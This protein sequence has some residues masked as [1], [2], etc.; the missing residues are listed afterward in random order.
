M[1][2]GSGAGLKFGFLF[3]CTAGGDCGAGFSTREKVPFCVRLWVAAFRAANCAS[4]ASLA[5]LED[6]DLHYLKN[7]QKKKEFN[8]ENHVSM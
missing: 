3:K 4:F 7:G 8:R 6:I 5:A 2:V 1:V